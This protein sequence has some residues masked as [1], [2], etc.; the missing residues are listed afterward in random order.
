M[1]D[2]DARHFTAYATNQDGAAWTVWDHVK[3]EAVTTDVTEAEA[4]RLAETDDDVD[5]MC[6]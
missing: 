4:R 2:P 5:E 6:R 3:D 1:P